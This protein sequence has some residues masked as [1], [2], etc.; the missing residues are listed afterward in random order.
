VLCLTAYICVADAVP[1]HVQITE[2][3]SE[4]QQ[5][6]QQDILLLLDPAAAAAAVPLPQLDADSMPGSLQSKQQW[7]QQQQPPLPG[8]LLTHCEQLAAAFGAKLQVW[9]P[10]SQQA[11]APSPSSSSSSSNCGQSSSSSSS[12]IG[13]LLASGLGL[14][15]RTA[16]AAVA[17]VGAA[18]AA[19]S[20][21]TGQQAE[22]VE[23]SEQQSKQQ[24]EQRAE[25]QA[26]QVDESDVD[27][28]PD[29]PDFDLRFRWDQLWGL[30]C[31]YMQAMDRVS[32]IA[33]AWAM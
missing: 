8:D 23:Q 26:E 13:G 10:F 29:F 17:A 15:R 19:A 6:G 1:C 31:M 16:T 12:S 24:S 22:Q 7:R 18:T 33:V 25:Q 27:L 4:L 30:R 20:A 11:S 21:A 3:L 5:Q 9:Q 28:L 2:L 32:H 14:A